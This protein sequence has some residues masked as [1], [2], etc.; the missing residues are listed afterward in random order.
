MI[1]GERRRMRTGM[2]SSGEYIFGVVAFYCRSVKAGG[3]V[4]LRCLPY[5]VWVQGE[6]C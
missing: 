3:Y 5:A 4:F 6:R 1:A 2:K